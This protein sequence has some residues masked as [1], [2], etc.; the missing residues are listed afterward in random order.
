MRMKLSKAVLASC[1]VAFAAASTAY[2]GPDA[3]KIGVLT[4]IGGPYGDITG[5]GSVAA[6]QIAIDEIGGTVLG[7][8]IKLLSADHQHKPDVAVTL[9]RNWLDN[10]KIDAILDVPN[11]NILLLTQNLV[12][13]NRGILIASGGQSSRFTDDLC[14]PYSFQFNTDTFASAN[15]LKQLA[16]RPDRKKWFFVQVDGA[17]GDT[18]GA[19]IEAAIKPLGATVIGRVKHPIN[20]SDFASY[21]LQAQSSGAQV[22]VFISGGADTI[23]AVKQAHE[24]G[25]GKKEILVASVLY[26]PMVKGMSL[27][28]AQ[29]LVTLLAYSWDLNDETRAWAKKFEAKVGRPPTALQIGV[30]SGAAHYLKAVAAAGTDDRNVVAAKMHELPVDNVFVRGGQIRPD[31]L[32]LHDMMLTEVKTISESRSEW[33]VFKVVEVIPGAE[34]LR[35]LADS[36]CPLVKK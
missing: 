9:L 29:G 21:L 33:D 4:D 31:G 15:G 19:D 3:I 10:E 28:S 27:A 20:T 36:K 32:L 25:I 5:K 35:P 2:A 14:S 8:P 11:S 22:I 24:F 26:E 23:N 1:I 16:K 30:Y 13:E 7:K 18:A 12:N 17:Y 34:A 6:A